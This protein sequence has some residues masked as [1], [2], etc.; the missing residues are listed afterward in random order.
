MK[1]A[2]FKFASCDG[3][4]LA[5]F[6][7]AEKLME[8]PLEISYFL[9]AQ[10][11]NDFEEVDVAFV[12][13]SISTEEEIRRIKEIREKSQKVIA[14]GA[15]SVSGGIQAI[16]NVLDFREVLTY[17]YP[18]P[19]YIQS[20][21]MSKPISDFVDVDFE[22]RGCP[23][24]KENLEEVINSILI[25]KKP[26]LP[27]YPVCLECKRK[28]NPCVLILG[29]PCIGGIT[30]AGCGAICPSF[31]LGCYGC[32][33]P[34]EDPNITALDEIFKLKGFGNVYE[35][36]LTSFNNYNKV[37]RGDDEEKG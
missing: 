37:Y 11:E 13:G 10:S 18:Q 19:E 15:C 12:E 32:F 6:D 3:C 8:L 17:V 1:V 14:I 29:K 9:E 7:L 23:I 20:L 31:N 21:E 4:Q 27:E 33:G 16:R 24:T 28:G 5:F 22:I 36:I 34:I 26:S 35:K 2:I 25:D 30:K